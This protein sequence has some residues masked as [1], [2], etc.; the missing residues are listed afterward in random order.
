MTEK[1]KPA[2]FEITSVELVGRRQKDG[3]LRMGVRGDGAEFDDWPAIVVVHGVEY[4]RA[5]E[6]GLVHKST[7]GR[8]DFE[9]VTYE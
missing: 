3:K 7:T 6:P 2:P 4:T 8:S 9:W 5:K 1:Y